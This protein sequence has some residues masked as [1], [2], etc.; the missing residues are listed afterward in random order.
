VDV[1]T[2]LDVIEAHGFDST[3][4]VITDDRKVEALNEA[5]WDICS[6]DPWPFLERSI[7][8][9]F[10]GTTGIPTNW[11][12]DV[13]APTKVMRDSDGARMEPFRL[14][15]FLDRY[16]DNLTL[17]ASPILYYREAGQLAVYPIPS[18]SETVTMKYV[19]VPAALT[20]TSLETDIVLPARFHRGALVNGA[21][22]RLYL[23]QDDTELSAGFE[24]LYEKAISLMR[25]DLWREQYE[26]PQFIHVNDPDNWDTL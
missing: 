10:D 15:D 5:Y 9:T 13:K 17:Q 18:A 22:Y 23:M 12:S 25:D 20:A 14:D 4:D 6:R 21:L 19:R 3:D 11:P 7:D 2:I 16:G 1:P 26:R 24:R 8:L